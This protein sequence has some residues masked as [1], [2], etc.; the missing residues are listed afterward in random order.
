VFSVIVSGR[1]AKSWCER[2]TPE[3]IIVTGIPGPG[4]IHSLT[5][6]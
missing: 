2:S 1:P 6:M 3:S 4:A 5:P